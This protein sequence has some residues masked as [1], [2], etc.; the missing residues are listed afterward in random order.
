MLQFGGGENYV[1]SWKNLIPNLLSLEEKNI[2]QIPDEGCG[3]EGVGCKYMQFACNIHIYIH[4]IM[5]NLL[6][7]FTMKH[8]VHAIQP[9]PGGSIGFAR[10]E[11]GV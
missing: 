10:W 1:F 7:T 11:C 5:A 3:N 6:L 8:P 4:Q 2:F 9:C